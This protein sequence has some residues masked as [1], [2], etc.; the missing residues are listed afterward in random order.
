MTWW[1][2][3]ITALD[4]ETTG[5]DPTEARIVTA[6][7]VIVNDGPTRSRA[8]L[9]DPGIV[10][11]DEATAIHGVTTE[12]AQA[13]GQPMAEVLAEVLAALA[14]TLGGPLVVFNARYDVTVLDRELRRHDR[15]VGVPFWRYVVDPFVIDKHLCRFRRGSRKLDAVCEYY[16][17]KL[18]GAHDA[19]H[20]ALAAARLAWCIGSR[21]EVV[22]R[23]RDE[24]D[25]RELAML[26]YEW[27]DV[28]GD[29]ARLH[30]AQI[31]WAREQAESLSEYF[32]SKG[33]PQHV[34]TAWPVIP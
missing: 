3:P 14:E 27:D 12:R 13:E 10:I 30:E 21:G 7:V 11:P 25:G 23:V 9:A 4:V 15:A 28:R 5:V 17:A 29:L 2:G 8:W 32:A 31:G 19:A 1:D 26:K 20:D 24:Q 16:G 33:E 6:C 22:R 18:D 34:E